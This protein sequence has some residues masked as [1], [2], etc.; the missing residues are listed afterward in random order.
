MT[1]GG[2]GDDSVWNWVSGEMERGKWL[3]VLTMDLL[4]GRLVFNV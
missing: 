3:T 4:P 2:R 1:Y